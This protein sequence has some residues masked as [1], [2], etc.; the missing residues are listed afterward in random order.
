MIIPHL[1]FYVSMLASL[2][3]KFPLLVFCIAFSTHIL[4]KISF[5]TAVSKT[6]SILSKFN[7]ALVIVNITILKL[8][9]EYDSNLLGA[10]KHITCNK[11]L[12]KTDYHQ[13]IFWGTVKQITNKLKIIWRPKIQKDDVIYSLSKKRW[14]TGK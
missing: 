4:V 8:H 1:I 12:I 13:H 7:T 9:D 2:I 11:S 5:M 6:P 10:Q 3:K 14:K